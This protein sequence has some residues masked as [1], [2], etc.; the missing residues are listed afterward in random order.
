V[1]GSCEHGNKYSGSIKFL[2][3]LG[4]LSDGRFFK[5][6]FAPRS[7]LVKRKKVKLSLYLIN[8]L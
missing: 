2:E 3:I 7:W 6:G 4:Y 5:E 1:E 8:L